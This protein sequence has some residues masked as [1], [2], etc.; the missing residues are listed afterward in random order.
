MSLIQ[1][2]ILIG[3]LIIACILAEL[4]D[5]FLTEYVHKVATKSENLQT[6]PTPPAIIRKPNKTQKENILVNIYQLQYEYIR[7]TNMQNIKIIE[8]EINRKIQI[9]EMILLSAS[10]IGALF[11]VIKLA[12]IVLM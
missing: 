5:I 3:V 12:S 6:Y 2:T 4:I 11:Y 9:T 8:T 10:L 1:I 7:K